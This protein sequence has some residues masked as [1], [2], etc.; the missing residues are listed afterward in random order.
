MGLTEALG[1][2]TLTGGENMSKDLKGGTAEP[3]ES[4]FEELREGLRKDL[5]AFLLQLDGLILFAAREQ[6]FGSGRRERLNKNECH[7]R[8]SAEVL[9]EGMDKCWICRFQI[10]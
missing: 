2:G 4:D 3:K 1:V 8:P 10:R 5:A 9:L 7:F 6:K